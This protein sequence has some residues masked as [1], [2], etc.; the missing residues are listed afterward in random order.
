MRIG[1]PDDF[2][3]YL[4][5][6]GA[7]VTREEEAS[8]QPLTARA[9]VI[10]AFLS[11]F[12]GVGAN[13]A[14]IVIKG[15]YMTLDFST[16][17]AIFVFLIVVGFL[18]TLFKWT[19]RHIGL[20]AAVTVLLASAWAWHFFPFDKLYLYSPGVLFSSFLVVAMVGNTILAAMGRN[21]ALN[22]SELIVV[23]IML[24][25]V[26][27]IATMGVCETILPAITG[28]FYYA[29]PEN[30]WAE[31][32]FPHL[33][34][35]IL[36][37][38]GDQNRLFY[39]GFGTTEYVV[40]WTI[41][42]RPM[43]VWGIF[44][45]SLYVAMISI[46]VILRRQWMDRE[47]LSYP[48]VQAAQSIIRGEDDDSLINPFFKSRAMWAGASLPMLVG[49][50]T[51]LNKYLGGWPLI[52]TAWSFP[53][54][55]GQSINM[56]ISFAVLGF[57][58]LIGPDIAMGI[59]GFALLSKVEKMVFVANGVTKQQDVWA[60]TVTELLNYQGMGA[61]FVF[62][63]I[64]LWVGR[65]HLKQVWYRF[66]GR[67]SE[68]SDDNEIMS[69]RAA[70]SGAIVGCLVMVG[71]FVALGTPVWA[72]ALFIFVLM[73][74]FT[75]LSRVVA[76]SGIAAIITPLNA[77]DFMIYGLGSKLLGAKAVT[78]F[79]F[80]YIYAADI[81][82][83]LMGIVASGLKLIEGM[84]KPDR[85]IVFWSILVAVFLGVCGS[86]YTVLE[87]GYKEGGINSNAWFFNSMPNIIYRTAVKGIE[88][89][90]VYWPGLGSMG[91]GGGAMLALTWLRQRFLWWPLHP[92]G[93][94]IMSSWLV[95]W[96][97]FSIFFAWLI[98]IIVLKY[99]GAGMY[100]K[101][102]NFFLG[103]IAGRMFISGG[104]I[105]VDYLTGTVSNSIFWI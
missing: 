96:M 42:I 98:K 31:I 39:E 60:V 74:I 67:D 20:S 2:R 80:G 21:L 11:F 105:V 14:D 78:N 4:S 34:D 101:S 26:A 59:W 49:L 87:L 18:N 70:V 86:L 7:S 71:W 19:G 73:V 88:N 68:L 9:L 43:A 17:G 65:E 45:L 44:L 38:D 40:P 99:G 92:I 95:D 55:F 46:S 3:S 72:S 8:H 37:N 102:R 104:W 76:E 22:R 25:V 50:F 85:R 30:K 10:G 56:T 64:G 93:F 81:R 53:I 1:L 82:V 77:P 48:L 5:M 51:G 57:S 29:S 36:L 75:G 103:M 13:Y 27:S 52:P 33:P 16:P 91:L 61:L 62:V 32:L 90:G 54:G 63:A 41:W 84:S 69:Y 94:P 79:T 15:S 47:R 83:F 97:W 89:E 24:V 35:M 6:R 28:I 23:Y 58:Y 66:L 12:L 100:A